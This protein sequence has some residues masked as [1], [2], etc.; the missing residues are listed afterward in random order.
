MKAV[1]LNKNFQLEDGFT[2]KP[3]PKS[4]EV[5][6]QIKASG[7]NPIDYQMLENE[8]ER[9]LISS[10]VLGRELSGIIVGKGSE[11]TQF[12]I[13][14][15]VYCGSGSM[16]S[17]GS[18]AEYITAPEDIVAFKPQ[19]L[20]FEQAAAIPST[21]LTALQ[22]FKRLK[23]SKEDSLLITG[24]AGG[25]GSFLIKF[26]IA[27]RYRKIIATVGSEENRQMLLN[28]G[29][30][31]D[32]IISYREEN[33]SENLFKANHNQ[34]FD[35]G[36]DLVGN[37]MSEITADLLKINGIYTDVTALVT[38]DAHETLF[39]KGMLIMNISNYTYSMTK[40]YSYY[41]N[42]LNEIARLIEN[43]MIN[44]PNYKIMGSLSLET[45]LKAHSILKNNQTQG[46]KLI[47]QH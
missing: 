34:L 36:I 45:V 21:G 19:N 27:H 28:I 5:L 47:M 25:V 29:L 18:Y 12:N 26:L 38:P 30:K 32:Q 44:P 40:T 22:I 14:D 46:H 41:R 7:F 15:E 11:A 1:I 31:N 23:P 17:N 4:N 16:G 33:L 24:A 42:G 3:I 9:R 43:N 10:P 35:I 2:E 37:R 13:G 20:S 6:I 39:N 8:L